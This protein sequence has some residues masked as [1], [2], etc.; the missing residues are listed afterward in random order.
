MICSARESCASLRH[1]LGHTATERTIL[2]TIRNPFLVKL[3]FAFQNQDKLYMVL[4]YMAG[5]ELFFW[6]KRDRKFREPRARLYAAEITLAL[7]C[8]HSYDIIYRDLKPENILLDAEGHI[9]ITDFGL[10]KDGVSGAGA[11]GG[12]HVS[13][14]GKKEKGMGKYG[15][16]FWVCWGRGCLQGTTVFF[17]FGR[18]SDQTRRQFFLPESKGN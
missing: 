3:N 17:F 2:Q 5:G 13:A 14:R 10:S 6:L 16:L 15:L 12:T 7:E 4:D 18:R 9:R 11:E 8:L 1:Q